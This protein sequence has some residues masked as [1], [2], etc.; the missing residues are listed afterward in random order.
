M[1]PPGPGILARIWSAS[2][3]CRVNVLKYCTA[4]YI[5]LS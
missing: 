4:Q 2:Q 1:N 3:D 5:C